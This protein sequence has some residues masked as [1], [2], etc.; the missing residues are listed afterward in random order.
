MQSD[1]EVKH[2]KL[3][4]DYWFFV[5]RREVI[6]S[7]LNNEVR[8]KKVLEIGCGSGMLLSDLRDVGFESE[9]IFGIDISNTA[10][11]ACQARNISN[12]QLADGAKLPFPDNSFDILI[13]SDVLEHIENDNVTLSEWNRVLKP[14]GKMIMLVPAF[15]ALWSEH[16]EAN[17]HFRRYTKSG[18]TNIIERNNFEI[19]R[20]SFWNI[21]L[22]FPALIIKLLLRLFSRRN[23]DGNLGN[24]SKPHDH[25]YGSSRILNPVMHAII[26]VDNF[27]IKSGINLP[28]GVSL[29]VYAKKK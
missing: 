1:Y 11:N 28:F 7:F 8:S 26:S 9:N 6:K 14:G 13:S 2:Y 19:L 25:L 10:I 18:L 12:V 16:D 24:A 23:P 5:A 21:T 29:L 17:L 4:K 3:E 15:P 27:L 20:I 22:F